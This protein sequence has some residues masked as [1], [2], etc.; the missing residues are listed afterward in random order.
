ML[1][2]WTGSFIKSEMLRNCDE[3]K[4]LRLVLISYHCSAIH[5]R[6]CLY[7]FKQKMTYRTVRLVWWACLVGKV[8]IM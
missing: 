3:V 7:T 4:I 8:G 2:K 5:L 1:F 6:T